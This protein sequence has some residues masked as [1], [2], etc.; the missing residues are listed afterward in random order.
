MQ[1]PLRRVPADS[2][3]EGVSE[4]TVDDRNTLQQSGLASRVFNPEVH[5]KR[6]QRT[7]L[8][9]MMFIRDGS[10]NQWLPGARGK[11]G[12]CR[13]SGRCEQRGIPD[14]FIDEER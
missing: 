6:R 9:T 4:V 1:T 5:R 3:R 7:A 12:L 14:F 13:N 8:L 2:E 10:K 11:V